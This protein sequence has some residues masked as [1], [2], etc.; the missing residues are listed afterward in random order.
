MDA[1]T[2]Y[3]KSQDSVPPLA[4]ELERMVDNSKRF[5]VSL[6]SL[7]QRLGLQP[8]ELNAINPEAAPS[9]RTVA[10]LLVEL[11]DSQNRIAELIERID[12]FVGGH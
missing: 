2:A 7:E 11:S 4:M 1:T 5:E 10:V 8:G 9:S 6:R 12:A 3:V